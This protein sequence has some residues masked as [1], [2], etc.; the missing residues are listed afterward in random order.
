MKQQQTCRRAS[1]ASCVCVSLCDS[2]CG[3]ALCKACVVPPG[4]NRVVDAGFPARRLRLPLDW[5]VC[6]GRTPPHA[7]CPCLAVL[8]PTC[9]AVQLPLLAA[10]RPQPARRVVVDSVSHP[11]R[12]PGLTC[13]QAA[14]GALLRHRPRRAATG[15]RSGGSGGPR[16]VSA[17]AGVRGKLRCTLPAAESPSRLNCS[18]LASPP[19]ELSVFYGAVARYKSRGCSK[20]RGEG[21]A[22][23]TT[24]AQRSKNG[25]WDEVSVRG[26]ARGREQKRVRN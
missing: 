3:V 5:Q 20:V 25:L 21:C 4:P 19:P 1:G 22:R 12:V 9:C 15:G 10:V 8:P 23:K 2:V 16:P 18:V 26:E 17:A 14:G 11:P 6:Q 7:S 13:M 24:G